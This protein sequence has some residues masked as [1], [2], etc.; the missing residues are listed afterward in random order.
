MPTIAAGR[1]QTSRLIRRSPGPRRTHRRRHPRSCAT[2]F[3][4]TGRRTPRAGRGRMLRFRRSTLPEAHIVSE[5]DPNPERASRL[6]LGGRHRVDRVSGTARSNCGAGGCVDHG[7]DRLGVKAEPSHRRRICLGRPTPRSRRAPDRP[8]DEHGHRPHLPWRPRPG[9]RDRRHGRDGLGIGSSPSYD[10]ERLVRIDPRLVAS[11]PRSMHLPGFP[12]SAAGLSG[13]PA[14][15]GSIASIPEQYG[16]R[17]DQGGRVLDRHARRPGILR[18]ARR[19]RLNRC[20]DRQNHEA[21][22]RSGGRHPDHRV[23]WPD[24]G[25]RRE[26]ALGC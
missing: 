2:H 6:A 1:K 15:M 3:D 22:R 14:R 25:R 10:F 26:H 21:S 16:R 19:R 18:R 20:C 17:G 23:R 24:L 5:P 8:G 12:S 13:P 7:D 9:C 11:S 4:E